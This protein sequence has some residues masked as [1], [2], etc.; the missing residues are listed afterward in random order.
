[1]N[2]RSNKKPQILF[3]IGTFYPSQHGGPC[4]TIY[5]ITRSL[6]KNGYAV[7]IPTTTVGI[8]DNLPSSQWKE[9]NYGRVRYIKTLSHLPFHLIYVSWKEVRH[10]DIVHLTSIF[11]PLSFF[12]FLVARFYGKVVVWSPR[13]ELDDEA[14]KFKSGFKEVILGVIKRFAKVDKLYFHSTAPQETEY[15]RKNYSAAANIIEVPNYMELPEYLD[16]DVQ[17]YLL[18]LGRIHPKKNLKALIE[19]VAKSKEFVNSNFKLIVAGD[20]KN[21]YGNELKELVNSLG[22]IKQV[23]FVGLITSHDKQKLYASAYF[24]ILPSLTENFGN[25]VVEA[26][27]QGTPVIASKGTPWSILPEAKAGFWADNTSSDIANEIDMAIKLN[28]QEYQ[29]MRKNAIKLVH[30][31]FDIE[32]NALKWPTLYDSIYQKSITEVS[33]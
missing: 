23:E 32:T 25:V 29:E 24:F 8:K 26:L 3:P 30:A 4:N 15:I 19:G 13:G 31:K 17:P 28:Q 20:E 18:Y 12:V 16:A 21:S 5:W 9:T 11:Y 10:H 27:A 6:V 2:Y 14:L 22:L 1:M 33:K 7:S